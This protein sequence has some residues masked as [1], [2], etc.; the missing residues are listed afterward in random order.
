[1]LFGD[2]SGYVHSYPSTTYYDGNIST[3]A[4]VA[5]YQTKW[6]RYSDLSLGD[7]YWRVLKTYTLSESTDTFLYVDCKSDYEQSGKV[8]TLDLGESGALWDVALWDVDV[9]GGQSLLVHRNEIEKGKDMFQVRYHNSTVNQGFTI[10]G[11]ENF[12]EPTERD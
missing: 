10:F 11:Y 12:I 5:F 1:M 4:I 7:K 9:W 8:L 6:F 3:H 2:Y